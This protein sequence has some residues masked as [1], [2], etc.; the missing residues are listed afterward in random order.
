MAAVLNDGR[1]KFMNKFTPR[2]QGLGDGFWTTWVMIP[3]VNAIL[4]DGRCCAHHAQRIEQRDTMPLLSQPDCRR[5]SINPGP[6]YSD[7]C[8]HLYEGITS[9]TYAAYFIRAPTSSSFCAGCRP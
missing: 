4:I 7:F 5:C 2:L 9:N 3:G 6:S 1:R 8:A